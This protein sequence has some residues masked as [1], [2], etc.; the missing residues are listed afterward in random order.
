MAFRKTIVPSG[1]S[2]YPERGDQKLN[3]LDLA[4]TQLLAR[5]SSK[6]ERRAVKLS[7]QATLIAGYAPL[8]AAA[9]DEELTRSAHQLRGPLLRHGFRSDLMAQSLALVGE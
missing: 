4:L 7:A 6:F 5:V 3:S 8:F 9:S 2:P 1:R